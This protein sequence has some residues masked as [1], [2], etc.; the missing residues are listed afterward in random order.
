MSSLIMGPYPRAI[1]PYQFS[2]ASNHL[3]EHLLLEHFY[4]YERKA[5]EHIEGVMED[6]GSYLPDDMIFDIMDAE[7][8]NH[9]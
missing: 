9:Q 3:L 7:C 6:V 1:G 2:L 8:L 4:P 5:T